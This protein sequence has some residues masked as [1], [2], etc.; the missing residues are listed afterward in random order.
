M[1]NKHLIFGGL[2]ALFIALAACGDAGTGGGDGDT[3]GG[4][5]GGS[6]SGGDTGNDLGFSFYGPGNLL[7]GTGTGIEDWEEYAPGMTFPVGNY[8][9][10]LNSQVHNPGGFGYGGGS[11]CDS[12]NYE[13]PW[14][15]TFC[16]RRSGVSRA[17]RNCP[18]TEVH[19]GVDIRGG[20]A[21][22]CTSQVSTPRSERSAIEIVAV[23]DGYIS[24]IGSYTVNVNA[25]GRIYRYMHL[26]MDM[27]DVALFDDVSAGDRIGFMSNHFGSTS[28]TFHLHFE[29]KE[30]LDEEGFTYVS[31]Y[32]SLVRA[33]E[34]KHSVIGTFSE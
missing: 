34:R 25:G 10:Y 13:Y 22:L 31:P 21:G 23:E 2:L 1:I 6:D 3:D 20:T 27:L 9:A 11:Q 7:S 5:G 33:Y 32:M 8:E 24:Y 15:D 18:S 14:R 4:S 30:N 12:G 19:Q 16:E 29:M 17:T 26:N 28:T